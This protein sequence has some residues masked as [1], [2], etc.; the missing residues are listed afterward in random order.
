MCLP[1]ARI[2]LSLL[3]TLKRFYVARIMLGN[4]DHIFGITVPSQFAIELLGIG[5]NVRF[6]SVAKTKL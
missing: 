3:P 1:V 4:C 2:K 6:L 5:G